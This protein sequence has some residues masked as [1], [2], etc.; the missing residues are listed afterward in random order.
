M[1]VNEWNSMLLCD[2]SPRDT[3]PAGHLPDPTR[4]L[5]GSRPGPEPRP[6]SAP[7]GTPADGSGDDAGEG[8]SRRR[9]SVTTAP[10]VIVR[11]VHCR[12]SLRWAGQRSARIRCPKCQQRLV[13]RR[14]ARG[15]WRVYPEND[16]S[17]AGLICDWLGRR[18]DDDDPDS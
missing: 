12:A 16:D 7:Q 3:E 4:L 15:Q 1:Q 8:T 9:A 2:V 18:T 5:S 13:L 14:T 6:N 17:V 11:C 10:G